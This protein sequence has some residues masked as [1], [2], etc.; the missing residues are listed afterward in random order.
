[1]ISTAL[2]SLSL[3]AKSSLLLLLDSGDMSLTSRLE[4]EGK[5]GAEEK[6]DAGLVALRMQL[7]NPF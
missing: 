3:A 7:A 5:E 6:G 2:S 4:E 1:M